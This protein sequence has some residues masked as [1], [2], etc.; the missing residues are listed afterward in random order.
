MSSPRAT[1]AFHAHLAEATRASLVRVS[2]TDLEI[3][4]V[5]PKKTSNAN[6][7]SPQKILRKQSRSE[8]DGAAEQDD[9]APLRPLRD[10]LGSCIVRLIKTMML[11]SS[12]PSS[13]ACCPNDD[14][15]DIA[16]ES[17]R[18]GASDPVDTLLVRTLCEMVKCCE[19]VD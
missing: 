6:A 1:D 10:A 7:S 13:S 16:P 11:M 15:I 19:E 2:A 5:G 8:D 18:V 9:H 3:V 14:E 12:S 4:D 17:G